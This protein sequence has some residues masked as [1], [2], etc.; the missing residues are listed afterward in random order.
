MEINAINTHFPASFYNSR[1]NETDS[2]APV[3]VELKI[4]KLRPA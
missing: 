1:E 2:A 4:L 3:A